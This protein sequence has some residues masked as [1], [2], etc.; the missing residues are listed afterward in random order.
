MIPEP[1]AE[2]HGDGNSVLGQDDGAV[3]E[4]PCQVKIVALVVVVLAAV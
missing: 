2:E 3:V 4:K 1:R